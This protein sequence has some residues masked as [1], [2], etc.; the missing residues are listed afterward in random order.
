VLDHRDV[1]SDIALA[2]RRDE[3]TSV[4]AAVRCQRDRERTR[5]VLVKHLQRG[6]SLGVR[7]SQSTASYNRR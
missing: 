3:I 1:R 4:M 5:Q 2:K 7:A 6:F